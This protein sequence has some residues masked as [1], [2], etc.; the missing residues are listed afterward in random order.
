MPPSG[1]ARADF[2]AT[3]GVSSLQAGSGAADSQ[4][5]RTGI[6]R[7]TEQLRP[8][9]RETTPQ[10]SAPAPTVSR[11]SISETTRA[12]RQ[13]QRIAWSSNMNKDIMRCHFRATKCGTD[14]AGYRARQHL[15][16]VALYPELSERLT[17]QNVAD[18]CRAITRRLLLPSIEIVQIEQEILEE[19]RPRQ[20][21]SLLSRR[22]E[23][24]H[25]VAEIP[26]QVEVLNEIQPEP[27]MEE[28]PNQ[29][30][31]VLNSYRDSLG[32]G[33][34]L[35][36]VA[37]DN[38][39]EAY[40]E[41]EGMDPLLRPR[42]PKVPV[43][44][45][46]LNLI[47][48]MNNIIDAELQ[49]WHELTHVQSV[50]FCAAV[51][52]TRTLG[53][54]VSSEQRQNHPT[55]N[56]KP[57][58]QSRL[59]S[60]IS[61][62]RADVGRLMMFK[63]GIRSRKLLRRIKK[64]VRP[65]R[66]EELTHLDLDMI[67][68][69]LTQ[70]LQVF[71]ARLKRYLS[72][73]KR[74]E[75]NKAFKAN[76]RKFYASLNGNSNLAITPIEDITPFER[77]W[78]NVWEK[79]ETHNNQA[80]WLTAFQQFPLMTSSPI[81]V[82]DLREVLSNSINWK[83]P[84][85]DELQNFWLKRL[86][87][88]HPHVVRCFNKI[89]DKEQRIPEFF[90]KGRTFLIPKN[91]D[92]E[93][94]SAFRPITCLVTLYKAF[95]AIIS[96]RIWQHCDSNGIIPCE[97]KGCAKRSRGCKELITIDAIIAQNSVHNNRN[98]SVAYIDYQKA[99]D[100]VPHSYLIEAL[101]IHGVDNKIV[102]FFMYSMDQWKTTIHVGGS[103]TREICVRRGLFQGDS[104]SPLWFCLSLAPLS[105]L[106]NESSNGYRIERE[107]SITHL[108]Y[109]DDLKL[110]ARSRKHL[111]SLLNI[112][113]K[114][115]EDIKMN[116]GFDKC[117]AVEMVRGKIERTEGFDFAEG[118]IETLQ[119][120]EP[121][122]Y[123]GVLEMKSIQHTTMKQQLK[124]SFIERVKKLCK[125]KLN[126]GN[127]TKAIN[128]FAIPVLLYSFGLIKWSETDLED[129]QRQIR[130]VLTSQRFHHPKSAIER[131]TL[132][133]N[134]GGLGILDLVNQ[135]GMQVVKL[136]QYFMETSGNLR[137]QKI[138]EMDKNFTPLKLSEHDYQP[139]IFTISSRVEQWK[140][141]AIHGKYPFQLNSV[142]IDKARS[143]EWL[144]KGQLFPETEGFIMA[145]QDGVV[146][147]R[148]YRR[149][150]L[151]EDI[152]NG[153]RRCHQSL[154]SIEHILN[155]CSMLANHEYLK[156]HND[157]AKIIHQEL[158]LRLKLISSKKPYYEYEADEVIFNNSYKLYWDRQMSTDHTILA[159]RP[160]I[161]WIDKTNL[162]G[163]IID[164]AVPLTAN[165]NRTFGE[166]L[167]KYADLAHEV[168]QREKLRSIRIVPIV[169]SS[170]GMIGNNVMEEL[171]RMQ[172]DHLVHDILKSIILNSCRT[173]RK[174]LEQ[175]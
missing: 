11:M 130:V 105:K 69:R 51:A 5:M 15:H 147:T 118:T 39:Q 34:I 62:Q 119:E 163:F 127:L 60:K 173:V 21:L 137:Y 104:F 113:K 110:F 106:L 13:R 89:L 153:C 2:G 74:R 161:V 9:S 16:F 78:E 160:D 43:T 172:C 154:E 169:V 73:R 91:R 146:A 1:G 92:T 149:A 79:P 144:Q 17:E 4:N 59:E 100:N 108:L 86:T 83:A 56:R 94:P 131:T 82:E 3:A 22:S 162:C 32:P 8:I 52:I 171:K 114:F 99:Y 57:V 18:R 96:N 90:T 112:V 67:I 58:W 41:F 134:E 107:M 98:L 101:R 103:T 12:G 166:K 93:N 35:F 24:E 145:I 66:P 45:K 128:S 143:T 170:T 76:Q 36:Q 97:Q 139:H 49:G 117:K 159:N 121:Y 53:L 75:D 10:L 126:S 152:D 165:L 14:P 174:F 28:I 40:I 65:K 72:I 158:A 122:K 25:S 50:I 140:A 109:I 70:K 68:D 156:R 133:R 123:L 164:I 33:D 111:Q 7:T 167:S 87:S 80:T 48:H 124:T 88:A 155:G 6:T 138:M 71:S 81:S 115:S 125:T 151:H 27:N 129:L 37:F 85:P 42:I 29:G 84:G 95:T 168:K 141:K 120:N 20:R 54:T 31:E 157:V 142:D 38:F 44:K 136:R 148:Q 55:E 64:I 63:Q 150:I 30:E 175:P 47:N 132:P 116:F 26:Q 61:N 102:E 46:T 19:L 77:F 23:T 135:Q